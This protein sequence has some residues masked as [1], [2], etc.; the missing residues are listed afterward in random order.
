MAPRR[1]EE[2]ALILRQ[3][4]SVNLTLESFLELG[5]LCYDLVPRDLLQEMKLYFQHLTFEITFIAAWTLNYLLLVKFLQALLVDNE[6][7]V[8][9]V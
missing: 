3:G 6:S 9:G 7:K 8:Y 2:I 1:S 5:R 4:K